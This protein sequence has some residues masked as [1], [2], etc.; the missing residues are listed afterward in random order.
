MPQRST[1]S[2]PESS[3]GGR[4][5]NG[6]SVASGPAG[7]HEFPGPHDEGH[8]LFAPQG[9]SR[10][11]RNVVVPEQF[12][13]RQHQPVGG[14]LVGDAEVSDHPGWLVGL[15]ELRGLD[16]VA[17]WLG[18]LGKVLE[19][20]VEELGQARYLLFLDLERHDLVAPSGLEEED[21]ATLGSNGACREGVGVVPVDLGPFH[22]RR[23]YPRFG[24]GS[25]L[26]C[27]ARAAPI[28]SR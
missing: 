16:R 4:D 3:I 28:W 15:E 25:A 12:L 7:G 2:A 19:E 18:S 27:R 14:L 17:R 21:A 11:G 9:E 6:L 13:H 20:A 10:L 22:R 5:R 24:V 8:D 26:I 23:R 1:S